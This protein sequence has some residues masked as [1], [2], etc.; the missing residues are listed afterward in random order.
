MATYPGIRVQA[1][2][3]NPGDVL[4]TMQI[5]MPVKQWLIIAEKLSGD[6]Y[7]EWPLRASILDVVRQIE[8]TLWVRTPQE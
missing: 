7:E 2:F 8:K 6:T 4:A 3:E 5:T 1:S